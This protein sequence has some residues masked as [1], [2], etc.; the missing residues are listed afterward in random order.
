LL[1]LLKQFKSP[2]LL[3]PMAGD[4]GPG[5]VSESDLGTIVETVI[6]VG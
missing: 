5:I 2:M 3:V 1:G 4:T 6:L